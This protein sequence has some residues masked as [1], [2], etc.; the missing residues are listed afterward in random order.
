MGK[1]KTVTEEAEAPW[2]TG[3]LGRDEKYVE[4][5]PEELK[6]E[7][8]EALAL[9]MISVRLQKALVKE[10]KFIADY[11]G[12]GYQPLIREVLSRFARAE[13]VSIANELREQE[14]AR[15]TIDNRQRELRVRTA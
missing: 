4:C 6:T 8:D 11:R 2:E 14:K 3:E 5:A 15:E 12:L 7:I 13:V 1:P 10:L 9:Q